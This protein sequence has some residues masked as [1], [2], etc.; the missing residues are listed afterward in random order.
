[1]HTSEWLLPVCGKCT[2]QESC[3]KICVKE[4]T[5]FCFVFVFWGCPFC[6]TF[7]FDFLKL[8]IAPLML[9]IILLNILFLFLFNFKTQIS[10]YILIDDSVTDL[11][12]FH[13]FL[14]HFNC[15]DCLETKIMTKT[16]DINFISNNAKGI[17]NS[18]KRL[19]MFNY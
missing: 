15:P 11:L 9:K 19:K 4:G 18:L 6:T 10:Y 13:I 7:Y 17:Q 5:I 3:W 12:M 1:M 16:T 14:H 8:G 2:S